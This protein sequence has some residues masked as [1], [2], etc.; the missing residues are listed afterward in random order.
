MLLY[1]FS[2]SAVQKD[3]H[4][5]VLITG[6]NV[7]VSI[8]N[9]NVSWTTQ[10]AI[11]ISSKGNDSDVKLDN[12][13]IY[14]GMVGAH[15]SAPHPIAKN[16]HI[17]HTQTGIQL[18]GHFGMDEAKLE[19][20]KIEHVAV[21][22]LVMKHVGKG[23]RAWSAFRAEDLKIS[24]AKTAIAFLE[25]T[26]GHATGVSISDCS[27]AVDCYGCDSLSLDDVLI[28]G[29]VRA[30]KSHDDTDFQMSSGLVFFNSW[31]DTLAIN[32]GK[33]ANVLVWSR[34]PC[35]IAI[36]SSYLA[37]GLATILFRIG[38]EQHFSGG[39]ETTTSGQ[40]WK[41]VPAA[42]SLLLWIMVLGAVVAALLLL[43]MSWKYEHQRQVHLEI[44]KFYATIWLTGL[45]ALLTAAIIYLYITVVRRRSDIKTLADL[46]R[47]EMLLQQK[48]GS[49]GILLEFRYR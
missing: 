19:S 11:A 35:P 47:T 5:Q 36:A 38:L 48:D 9:T 22:G 6:T 26:G 28:A 41:Y 20:V 37:C 15:L 21:V 29:N 33:R 3:V 42:A 4:T 24:K 31:N 2:P 46:K 43:T 7:N 10:V 45:L 32:Q 27:V 44:V 18:L 1:F 34:L 16:M 8:N 39:F 12:I 25:G 13:Q 40:M 14:R 23:L 17:S 30:L 49:T